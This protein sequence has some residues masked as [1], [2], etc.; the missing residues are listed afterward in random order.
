[1]ILTHVQEAERQLAMMEAS[2]DLL[3]KTLWYRGHWYELF[4]AAEAGELDQ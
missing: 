1:M 2:G 3:Y 4:L